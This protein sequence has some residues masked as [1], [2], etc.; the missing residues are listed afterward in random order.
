MP[1]L[2]DAVAAAAGLLVL[3]IALLIGV[4]AAALR[5]ISREQQFRPAAEEAL[6]QYLA[7]AGDA[8]T[9]DRPGQRAVFLAIAQEALADLRGAERDRLAAVALRLG[10]TEDAIRRLRARRTAVRRCAAETARRGTVAAG[11]QGRVGGHGAQGT[12]PAG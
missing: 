4:R 3:L 5:R 12:V 6:G 1:V 11:P 2:A 8:P 9:L 10:Y 7:G